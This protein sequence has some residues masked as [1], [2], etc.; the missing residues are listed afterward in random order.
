MSQDFPGEGV[1]LTHILVVSDM[2]RSRDFYRALC[3]SCQ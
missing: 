2:N 1:K 3:D